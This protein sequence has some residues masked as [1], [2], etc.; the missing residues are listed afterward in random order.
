MVFNAFNK[1]ARFD[2]WSSFFNFDIWDASFKDAG[3]DPLFYLKEKR[4]DELLPWDFIETGVDKE[5]LVEEFN[6]TIAR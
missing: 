2:T 1:G 5:F 6:K 3:V 4:V